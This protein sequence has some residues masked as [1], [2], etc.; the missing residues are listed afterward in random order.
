MAWIVVLEKTFESP[1]DSQDIKAVNRKEIN[2]E[3]LLVGWKLKLKL[4]CLLHLM[5]R[6]DL[7]EETLMLENIVRA[8]KKGA[9]E[10]EMVR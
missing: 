10:Y 4:H 2:P 5:R 6:A 8:E 7:L 3:C 9:T 1:L